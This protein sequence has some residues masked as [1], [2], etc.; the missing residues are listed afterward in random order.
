VLGREIKPSRYVRKR[1][2][3]D[4]KE[5]RQTLGRSAVRGYVSAVVD[6]WSFQKSSGSNSHPNP[7]GEGLNAILGAHTRREHVRKRAQFVDRAAGTLQEGYTEEK[8]LDIVR[9][10][11]VGSQDRARRG[12]HR[13][14]IESHLRTAVDFLFSHNML[15]RS[16][17]RLGAEFADLFTLP[18]PNEGPTPCSAMFFLMGNGKTNPSQRIEYGAVI[19][20]RNPLLCTMGHTAFYLFFRWNVVRE[21][22]PR[23]QQR[24]QWYNLRLLRGSRADTPLSYDTQLEWINKIFTAA[25]FKSRSKTHIP[26]SQG[27]K[28]AEINGVGEGQIRR[29]G[30][31]NSDALTTCYLTHLPRK[32]V[33]SMAGFDPSAKGNYYLPRAKILPPRSLEMAVWPWVDT[34]LAWFESDDIQLNA[35]AEGDPPSYDIGLQPM[36]ASEEDRDDLAGQGFLRLLKELRTVFLQDSVIMRRMF[37]DH[38]IWTD[39]IFV[40]E[41]YRRFAEELEL[42]LTDLEEPEEIRIRRTLPAIAERL[43]VV[44]QGITQSINEWG[45]KTQTAIK[46]VVVRLDDVLNGRV[47]FTVQAVPASSVSASAGVPNPPIPSSYEPAAASSAAPPVADSAAVAAI[48]TAAPVSNAPSPLFPVYR[49]SRT[50]ET[51]PDLWR[52]W[53]VGLGNGPA[54]QALEDTYGASWRPDQ[55]ERVLFSRRKVIIDEIRKRQA[56]GKAVSVAVEE[57]ELVR[58]R[59][60]V[61]LY[62]LFE[63]LRRSKCTARP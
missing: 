60:R 27:A 55:K 43:N 54:V 15:L 59:A 44:K 26:R 14:S 9:A 39:P 45:A 37:P 3:E 28:M 52:E 56:D 29:A 57:V 32:F 7:R 21:P 30:H 2:T 41:D 6:L 62:G 46:D 34:W 1:T 58:Q 23:F 25:K 35:A 22:P 36:D 8:M 13:Q 51:V 63:L 24:Q 18:L 12:Q 40:R 49:L 48:S 53:T 4:G 5:I 16:E 20:H 42:S 33:R 50:I 19:R 47:S 61:S 10:C 31:W 38:V 17:S 11:W